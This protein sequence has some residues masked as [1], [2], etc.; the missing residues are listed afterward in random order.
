MRSLCAAFREAL[1]Q[2][3]SEHDFAD[4]YAQTLTYGSCVRSVGLSR[5]A[6]GHG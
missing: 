5:G 2:D 4:T 6:R 1:V 3:L